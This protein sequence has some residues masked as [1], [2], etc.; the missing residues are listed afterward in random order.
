MPTSRKENRRS[1]ASPSS[2]SSRSTARLLRQLRQSGARVSVAGYRLRVNAPK[3]LLSAELRQAVAEQKNQLL[4]VL[5]NEAQLLDMSLSEFA[6]NGCPIQLRV[7]GWAR[8]LWFVPGEG[9]VT[10][11]M[12]QGVGRGR[13]W[14]AAELGRLWD[15]G[16]RHQ[17]EVH[18]LS[19]MKMQ[20]G[21][22]VESVEDLRDAGP[23]R[24]EQ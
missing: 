10:H 5:R 11:L 18:S 14:T 3:G 16:I 12:A 19:H 22:E 6:Q 8:T 2:L 23:D 21:C 20:L 17:D 24:T 13:I 1:L 4:A 7:P 9:E 15:A